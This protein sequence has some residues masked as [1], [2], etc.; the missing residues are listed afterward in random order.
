MD[1]IVT[2]AASSLEKTGEDVATWL[3][4]AIS[5]LVEFCTSMGLKIVL[6]ILILIVGFKLIGKLTNKMKV[7]KISKSDP[8]VSSFARSFTNIGLKIILIISV[9]ALLGIPTTSM[10]AL[11]GSA[12]LA[13][14]LALQGSLG[15][16][17]G[18]FVILVFKPFVVGD[19]IQAG[20]N[21]GVITGINLFYT[22]I[23]TPDNKKVHIPNSIIS[24]QTIVDVSSLPTRRDDF[25]YAVA[26]D[27]DVEKVKSVL[28]GIAMNNQFILDDP[29]PIV[30]MSG[31][32]DSAIEFT[33]RV[34]CKNEDYWPL[35]Y[36]MNSLVKAAFDE[37]SIS[38]PYPQVD[39]H[40]RKGDV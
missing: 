29:A 4:S 31:H 34:W 28:L 21:S 6:G 15:N 23:V 1:N 12:G 10:V 30:F 20:D 7:S 36:E 39:V 14:G 40:I 37:N 32:G 22:K 8:T 3:D 27:S 33:L 2:D 18:G 5:S 35:T 11:I 19:F 17:A 26:Y 9:A 25:V 13:V 38:I 24:N 16:I